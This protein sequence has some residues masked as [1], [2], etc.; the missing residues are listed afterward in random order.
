MPEEVRAVL[1]WWLGRCRVW[2]GKYKRSSPG[3]PAP[4]SSLI[5][6]PARPHITSSLLPLEHRCPRGLA[7]LLTPSIDRAPLHLHWWL[8][9]HLLFIFT[10]VFMG[11]FG[12]KG[13]GKSKCS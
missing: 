6:L 2:R 13:E 1:I 11:C 4:P 12:K 5:S 7:V 10:L 8:L 9:L 3:H